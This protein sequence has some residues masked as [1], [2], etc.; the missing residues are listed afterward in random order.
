MH[1][2]LVEFGIVHSYQ[3]TKTKKVSV[4]LR[5]F[6]I[7]EQKYII[8]Q[9]IIVGNL[10]NTYHLDKY[11]IVFPVLTALVYCSNK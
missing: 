3:K 9:T 11:K 8:D 6:L 2:Y 4:F 7:C 5:S 1:H 10:V